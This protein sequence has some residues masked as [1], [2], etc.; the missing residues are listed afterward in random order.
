MSGTAEPGRRKAIPEHPAVYRFLSGH[1]L[2]DGPPAHDGPAT[3]FLH[4]PK[5]GGTFLT[6]LILHNLQEQDRPGLFYAPHWMTAGQTAK[7]FGPDRKLA[8]ILRDPVARFRS[9]WDS[10]LARGRPAYDTPWSAAEE[11]VFKRYP[12]LQHF[13]RDAVHPNPRNRNRAMRLMARMALV[14]RGYA[15]AFGSARKAE[16]LL[17]Q[18]SV[19][20]PLEHL[21]PHLDEVMRGLGFDSYNLAPDLTENRA[22]GQA[23]PLSTLDRKLLGWL[24]RE[25]IRIHR[26]L[27]G[28]ARKLHRL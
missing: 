17:D 14:P 25:D 10:R 4:I 6:D 15:H 19:C 18:I 9:A 24:L 1:G 21:A 22:T 27:L 11:K 20:L 5:T 16:A 3:V 12:T 28:H 8:L 13:L 2:P 7:I 23:T 26:V